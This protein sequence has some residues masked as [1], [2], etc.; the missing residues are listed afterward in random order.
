[1]TGEPESVMPR[2]AG[3]MENKGVVE[4]GGSVWSVCIF[5]SDEIW[6]ERGE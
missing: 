2:M 3:E 1:M 5:M 6:E 4:G